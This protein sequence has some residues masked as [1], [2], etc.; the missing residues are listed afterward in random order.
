MTLDKLQNLVL[1]LAN[2]M[3]VRYWVHWNYPEN[4]T[5]MAVKLV[6]D[7]QY[8]GGRLHDEMRRVGFKFTYTASVGWIWTIGRTHDDETPYK[9]KL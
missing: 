2:Q 6:T 3:P 1:T 9:S 5:T 7:E 8:Q 4:P